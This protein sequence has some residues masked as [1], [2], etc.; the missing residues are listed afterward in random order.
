M[1]LRAC[2]FKKLRM[3]QLSLKTVLAISH[4]AFFLA[5]PFGFSSG[6][7]TGFPSTFPGLVLLGTWLISSLA[8]LCLSPPKSI[9]SCLPPLFSPDSFSTCLR[10][11]SQFDV[12]PIHSFGVSVWLCMLLF[13]ACKGI[14][15]LDLVL[16]CRV[17]FL[18]GLLSLWVPFVLGAFLGYLVS[19]F[20][21]LEFFGGLKLPIF[22][23]ACV[24]GVWSS[25]FTFG[26]I[27][28]FG[29]LLWFFLTLSCYMQFVCVD[30]LAC[31]CSL[32]LEPCDYGSLGSLF[33]SKVLVIYW[34]GIHVLSHY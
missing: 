9:H 21:C 34:H 4:M 31:M 23:K 13:L 32:C 17:V 14:Y 5:L 16:C 25:Y 24:L 28:F 7:A 15:C 22:P 1:A 2:Y 20:C 11:I 3:E 18:C 10:L 12:H 27:L 26:S 8:R 29:F 30:F 6:L 19:C 33:L